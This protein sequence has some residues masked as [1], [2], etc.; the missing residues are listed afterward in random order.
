MAEAEPCGELS[1]RTVGILC[2]S[3]LLPLRVAQSLKARGARV[4]GV[5][6]RGEAEEEVARVADRWHWAGL[7]RLGRW[8]R[9]LKSANADVML[10]CGSIRKQRMYDS[11]LAM[12]PDLR[13]IKLWYGRLRS[14]QDHTILGAVADEFDKEGIAVGSIPEFCPD[15]LAPAGPLTERRPTRAQ[16]RDVRFGWP[17]AKQIAAMQIGQCIVVKDGAVLAVE[18]IDGTDATLERG[19][20]LAGGG[21]V[22]V[23]VPREGHDERFDIPCIGPDTVDTLARAGVDVLAVEAGRTIA[24]DRP[25]VERRA[26]D[27]GV[28]IVAVTPA[29]M[30][31]HTADD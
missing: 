10:M 27:A 31:D 21:A 18:G 24:L 19:G 2:G 16:W 13:T 14:R 4:V 20:R 11:K 30:A 7:A 26:R 22:A 9:L 29:Q 6:I 25:E 17:M 28:C 5:G 1:G 23:K 15:L 8:I 12:L 3:G